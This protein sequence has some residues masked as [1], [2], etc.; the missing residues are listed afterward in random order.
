MTRMTNSIRCFTLALGAIPLVTMAADSGKP[1]DPGNTNPPA[2]SAPASP[3]AP[4]FA[5]LDKD[6]DGAITKLEAKRS[7]EIS[8][9]FDELDAD[10]NGKISIAEWQAAARK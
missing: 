10:H 3:P 9:R 5:E 7:A 6:R 1:P 4:L 8:A 2:M